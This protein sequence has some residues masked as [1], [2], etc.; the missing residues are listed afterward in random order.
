MHSNA[1]VNCDTADVLGV[2]EDDDI[3]KA[4][5]HFWDTESI[6]VVGDSQNQVEG[7]PFLERLQFNNSHYEVHLPWR[8]YGLEVPDHF[9]LCLNRLHL[10]HAQL[11]KSPELL[12]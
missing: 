12:D 3:V 10:L 5:K 9:N 6:S 2:C 1:I 11:L 8:D 7:D 4:L